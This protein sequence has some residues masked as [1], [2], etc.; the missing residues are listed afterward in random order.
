[1]PS[2][3]VITVLHVSIDAVD[4]DELHHAYPLVFQAMS[5]DVEAV[6]HL[7]YIGAYRAVATVTVDAGETTDLLHSLK[8]ACEITTSGVF[9]SSVSWRR[10]Q[11]ALPR[12]VQLDIAPQDP[13]AVTDTSSGIG[14]L[15]VCSGR[16]Y[17]RL[18]QGIGELTDNGVSL[19]HA[20]P[21][22]TRD[23]QLLLTFNNGSDPGNGPDPIL[24]FRRKNA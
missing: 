22:P 21:D 8:L 14:T 10:R 7:R 11:Q 9:A 12:G 16:T 13:S 20:Q 15:F 1:M 19:L 5:G 23:E 4:P 3:T 18:A 24:S 2:D 6:R 17:I